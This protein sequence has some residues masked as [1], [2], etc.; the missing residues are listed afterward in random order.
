MEDDRKVLRHPSYGL[1]SI[2]RIS[3]SGKRRLFGS[4]NEHHYHTVRIRIAEA[5]WERRDSGDRFYGS[6]SGYGSGNV[7]EVEL[8][9][10]QFAEFL[11]TS[12]VGMGVPC[13]IIY[14][15]GKEV[16]S[17]PDVRVETEEIRETFKERLRGVASRLE[18]QKKA[19]LAALPK[20]IPDKIRQQ[21][22]AGLDGML[23]EITDH[24][25]FI[26]EMFREATERTTK[27]AKAEID[28]LVT[29]M[30]QLTGIKSLRKLG[31]PTNNL[32][33]LPEEG[34][35]EDHEPDD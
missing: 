26:S 10:A 31:S 4:A 15:E 5:E 16:E 2:S 22:E 19:T 7:V 1:I 21:V 29:H 35:G 33:M 24:A 3:S 30:I 23:R 8:S 6:M 11:T 20:S 12:N 14:R 28:A 34:S 32:Q 27:A 25:P 13:T 18:K 9:A 17:P